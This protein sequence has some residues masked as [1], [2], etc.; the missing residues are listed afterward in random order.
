MI[1]GSRV[2]PA[3][4]A[5][6]VAPTQTWVPRAM[7]GNMPPTISSSC[8]NRGLAPLCLGLY[9]TKSQR[10]MVRTWPHQAEQKTRVEQQRERK[11]ERERE[12]ESERERG[13]EERGCLEGAKAKASADVLEIRIWEVNTS[14]WGGEGW[15]EGRKE[16]RE[17]GREE[18]R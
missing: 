9:H 15:M 17:G 13:W 5:H 16:G 12:R 7:C 8:V 3:T 2:Q 1:G 18:G 6:A 14:N 11:R 4:L 10:E